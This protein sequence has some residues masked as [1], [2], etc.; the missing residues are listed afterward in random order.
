[1]P[2]KEKSAGILPG[3]RAFLTQYGAFFTPFQA[4]LRYGVSPKAVLFVFG[5]TSH[6]RHSLTN[7]NLAVWL[8]RF[9]TIS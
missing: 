6:F 2:D 8:F 1:V 4:M 9:V 3:S 7:W 5:S